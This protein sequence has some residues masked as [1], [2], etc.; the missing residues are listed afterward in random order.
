MSNFDEENYRGVADDDI[1]HLGA[2]IPALPQFYEKYTSFRTTS[3]SKTVQDQ[4][5]R[6]LGD[7]DVDFDTTPTKNTFGG[8]YRTVSGQECSFK[9]NLFRDEEGLVVEFQRASGCSIAFNV[10]Y[11]QIRRDFGNSSRMIGD[12]DDSDEDSEPFNFAL[13]H[14]VSDEFGVSL[15]MPTVKALYDM[16]LS[17]QLDQTRDGYRLL[18]HLA[19]DSKNAATLLGTMS[20]EAKCPSLQDVV[21]SALASEDAE[22]CRHSCIFISNLVAHEDSTPLKEWM[23]SNCISNLVKLLSTSE[24]ESKAQGSET[25][26]DFRPL[27]KRATR[28]LSAKIFASLSSSSPNC[29]DSVADTLRARQQLDQD[30]ITQTFLAQALQAC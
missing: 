2:P 7:A 11:N 27:L 9:A 16:V 3:D 14:D 1:N 26:M 30:N 6:S 12:D 13:L 15:D 25:S 10:V 5:I 20:E 22:T 17:Q 4:I 24:P 18:A 29:L 21:M 19:G 28:R 23:L 8:I